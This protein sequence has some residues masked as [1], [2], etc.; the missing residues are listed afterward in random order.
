MRDTRKLEPNQLLTFDTDYTRDKNKWSVCSSFLRKRFPEGRF[1]FLDVGGGNGVF[2]DK[3][4]V[5]FPLARGV[6]LDNARF[7]LDRNLP[8]LRK[9]LVCESV[10]KI[11]QLFGD[12]KFDVIFFN[13]LLH[14]LTGSSY[15][16]TRAFQRQV[17]LDA[18]SIL[19]FNGCIV[20]F[21]NMYDGLAINGFPSWLIYQITSSR[22]LYPFTKR[23]AN[24]AGCGVCF[25]SQTQWEREF[26]GLNLR[27]IHQQQFRSWKQSIWKK[28]LLH[29]GHRRIVLFVLVPSGET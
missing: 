15:G 20:V 17:F 4:L 18:K 6:V 9:H 23:F 12:E 10:V 1:R 16:S 25:L 13:W 21:E 8:N 24:T 19:S 27:V 7:L 2:A 26:E 3:T 22:M 29:I 14:H 28:L 5:E 11:P